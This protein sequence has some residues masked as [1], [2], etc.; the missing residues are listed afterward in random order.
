MDLK[1]HFER[2]NINEIITFIKLQNFQTLHLDEEDFTILRNNKLTG[3]SFLVTKRK[4]F[5]ASG[6][7]V[8]RSLEILNLKKKV[9][10]SKYR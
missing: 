6:L 9:I 4:H 8:Y 1:K 3:N 2:L 10:S 5:E 7:T